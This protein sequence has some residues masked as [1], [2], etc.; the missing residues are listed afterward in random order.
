MLFI[1]TLI[2]FVAVAQA[3]QAQAQPKNTSI[4]YIVAFASSDCTGQKV[5]QYAVPTPTS[6]CS[7]LIPKKCQSE[8][9]F[10]GY[11]TCLDSLPELDPSNQLQVTSYQFEN[12]T[13]PIVA[14][15]TQSA[16]CIYVG[17]QYNRLKQIDANTIQG[18]AYTDA[19]CTKSTGSTQ[20]PIGQ[21]I[22]VN[23]DRQGFPWGA[24]ARWISANTTQQK[25]RLF[26]EY[27]RR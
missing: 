8:N 19:A 4:Y 27:G 26:Q 24:N 11:Q 20:V 14:A 13:G 9:G 16:E 5:Y 25:V 10:S 23:S 18:Y 2:A 3:H 17:G 21:C 6:Q 15:I 7:S 1:T 22:L 12:C